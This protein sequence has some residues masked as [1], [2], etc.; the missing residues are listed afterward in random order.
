M[1]TDYINRFYSK[2]AKRSKKLKA[3]DFALAKEIVAWKENVVE[4]WDDV[5]EVD[6]Q[7]SDSLKNTTNDGDPIEATIKIDTA[8]LG[9][10][11]QVELVVYREEHGQIKFHRTIP[12][13]VVAEEGNVLTYHMKQSTKDSGVFRFGFRVFPWNEHLPHRQDFAYMKWL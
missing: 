5:H 7:L 9:K 4:K 3:N 12:F 11:L 8:G 10:D 6:I 1:M 2:E 13:D